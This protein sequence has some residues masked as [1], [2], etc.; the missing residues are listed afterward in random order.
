MTVHKSGISAAFFLWFVIDCLLLEGK[1]LE[2]SF[3]LLLALE[4]LGDELIKGT[5]GTLECFGTG[6]DVHDAYLLGHSG[7][8]ALLN[9][10]LVVEVVLVAHQQQVYLGDI[11]LLVD[12]LDPDVD[13]LEGLMVGD[14]E[15]EQD[16]VHVAVVVGRDGVVSSGACR[17][18]DL[19]ANGVAVFQLQDLLLVLHP[20]RGRVVHAELL[21]HVLGQQGALSHVA[22]P[23]YQ[24]LHSHLVLTHAL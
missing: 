9:L 13:Q 14:V 7:G 16:A 22:L 17:V 15:D 19:H 11:G 24:H 2:G 23:D 10:T 6:L 4:N 8:L 18:P 12:L 1:A 5:P 21:V 20:D 3:K